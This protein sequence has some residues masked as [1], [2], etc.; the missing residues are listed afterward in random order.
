[1]WL[2]V[3]ILVADTQTVAELQQAGVPVVAAHGHQAALGVDL[4]A[5]E[6]LVRHLRHHMK[7]LYE[8]YCYHD[9]MRT[10][11]ESMGDFCW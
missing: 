8:G 3:L 4:S 6:G 2:V 10:L 7:G 5:V 9:D 11:T 1:M